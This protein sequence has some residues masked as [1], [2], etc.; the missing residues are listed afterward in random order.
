MV[1]T[2]KLPYLQP[3]YSIGNAFCEYKTTGDIALSDLTES[4]YI[5]YIKLLLI[6]KSYDKRLEIIPRYQ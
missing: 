4:Y 1:I 5:D 2:E 6:N 3:H